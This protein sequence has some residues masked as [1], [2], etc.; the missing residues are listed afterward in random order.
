MHR[1][2]VQ[3]GSATSGLCTACPTGA[4]SAAGSVGLSSCAC[5]LTGLPPASSN[6]TCAFSTI[7]S[8]G[9]S[10][11]GAQLGGAVGG[12]IGA[13]LLVV[14]CVAWA[15]RRAMRKRAEEEARNRGWKA[16]IALP[17]DVVFGNAL[18]SGGFASVRG[19]M[20][21]PRVSPFLTMVSVC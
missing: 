19:C 21:R 8:S 16:L 1:S 18:G 2:D 3:S 15:A 12:P 7:A 5:L 11:T 17:E 10:I 20:R 13:F 14:C 9:K 6:V 4:T